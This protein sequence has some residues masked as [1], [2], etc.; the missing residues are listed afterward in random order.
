VACGR[1]VLGQFVSCIEMCCGYDNTNRVVSDALGDCIIGIDSDH[2]VG[3]MTEF[4]LTDLKG[5]PRE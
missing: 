5:E 1:E 3:T 2:F 4:M